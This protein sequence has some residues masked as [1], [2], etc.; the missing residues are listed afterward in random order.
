MTGHFQTNSLEKC[1]KYETCA[2]CTGFISYLAH[3]C[4]GFIFCAFFETKCFSQRP[5]GVNLLQNINTF[6]QAEKKVN[7]ERRKEKI[8]GC[9]NEEHVKYTT[10]ILSS[11][12]PYFVYGSREGSDESS[13]MPTRLRFP[14][15]KMREV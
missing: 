1:A 4:T 5:F 15:S 10:W 8:D 2:Y 13:Q 6:Q 3:F 14:G 12:H 9:L 7:N 11:S